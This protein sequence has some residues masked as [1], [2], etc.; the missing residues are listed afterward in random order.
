MTMTSTKPILEASARVRAEIEKLTSVIAT[1]PNTPKSLRERVA[2][3]EKRINAARE[4]WDIDDEQR[5]VM[6]D[7]LRTAAEAAEARLRARQAHDDAMTT[8][9][10]FGRTLADIV[11]DMRDMRASL[12]TDQPWM[13]IGAAE[14]L[15][16]EA[17]DAAEVEHAQAWREFNDDAIPQRVWLAR[18]RAIETLLAEARDIVHQAHVM[19]TDIE[20]GLA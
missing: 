17:R 1:S 6:R 19:Q 7:A 13:S 11:A 3:C 9:A 15:H 5:R 14:R 10:L 12:G 18:G 8:R 20:K 16:A 4:N 2:L